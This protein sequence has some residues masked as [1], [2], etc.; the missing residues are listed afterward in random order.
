MDNIKLDV[1]DDTLTITVDLSHDGGNS[2]SGKSKRIASS[3]G[4]VSIPGAEGVKMGL[5]IYRPLT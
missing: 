5:N 2:G 4:N 3:M 1:T